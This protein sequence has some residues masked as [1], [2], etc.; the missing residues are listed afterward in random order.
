MLYERVGPEQFGGLGVSFSVATTSNETTPDA[1]F[2]LVRIMF[3]LPVP[4]W[5]SVTPDTFGSTAVT[6]QL[7]VIADTGGAP[8]NSALKVSCDEGA[9]PLQMLAVLGPVNTGIS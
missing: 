4:V 7:N 1:P 9:V 6:V 2:L 8:P 5:L 3:R